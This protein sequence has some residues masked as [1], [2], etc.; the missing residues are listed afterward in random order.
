MEG[1]LRP[2]GEIAVDGDELVRARDLAR[3]DDLVLVE[4]AFERELRGLESREDHALG[5]DLVGRLPEGPVRILLH[6]AHDEFLVQGA[7]VHADPHGAPDVPRDGADRRELLVALSAA[8][9]VPG[10]D[11]I[12]V[13]GLG[14]LGVF[15]QE[16][17]A[18]VVEVADER[19][20][21]ACGQEAPLDFGNRPRGLVDVHGHAHEVRAR[22]RELEGLRHG[23]VDVGRVRVRHGL[24]DDGRSAP[25]PDRPDA[26]TDRPVA[27]ARRPV[28]RG[29]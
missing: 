18:V 17:V 24:D 6:L 3:D 2:A 21:A 26:H 19:D 27:R 11:P 28:G 29:G 10:V 7:A 8:P 16:D 15:R 13:E 14:H 1:L 5:D 22:L 20:V 25:D 12:L 4:P 9:D 23:A